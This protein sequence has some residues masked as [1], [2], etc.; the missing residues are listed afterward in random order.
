M[1][2][3]KWREERELLGGSLLHLST[4]SPPF[5]HASAAAPRSPSTAAQW[6]EEYDADF[7]GSGDNVFQP[8][9]IAAAEEGAGGGASD[10]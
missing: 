6:A 3:R 2:N 1:Q 7:S 10:D 5:S 8:T 9:I 4:P